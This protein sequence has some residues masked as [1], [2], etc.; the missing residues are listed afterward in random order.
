MPK[1]FQKSQRLLKPTEF[2]VVL[3][4]RSVRSYDQCFTLFATPNELGEPRLGLAIAKKQLRFAVQRNR[5]KR[6]VRES[7]RH[8]QGKMPAIDIV[9]M[10]RKPIA[11][12]ENAALHDTLARHWKTLAKRT[13][14]YT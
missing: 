9:V 4:A 2:K 13:A 1:L 10:V 5:I 6:L 14:K 11:D 12:Q 7:F 3:D 8:H